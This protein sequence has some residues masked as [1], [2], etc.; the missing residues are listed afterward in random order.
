MKSLNAKN[1]CTLETFSV[2]RERTFALCLSVDRKTFILNPRLNIFN[3]TFALV[4]IYNSN[5]FSYTHIV[6]KKFY[7]FR[8]KRIFVKKNYLI[9][10]HT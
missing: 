10:Q 8:N 5:S 6:L 3:L 1:R 2:Q 7:Y 9:T 4:L